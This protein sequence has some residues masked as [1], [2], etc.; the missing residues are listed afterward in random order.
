MIR[1]DVLGVGVDALTRQNALKSALEM[2]SEHRGAYMVTPNPEIVMAAW[3]DPKVCEA[4]SSAD[5]VIAD[6]VGVLMA[7]KILGRPLPER[8]TG[9][10]IAADIMRELS[11]TGGSVFL[12]GAKAGVAE[13]AARNIEKLFPGLK[14]AGVND[15]YAL[16]DELLDR[17]NALKPDFLLVCLGAGR[18]ELWMAKNAEKLDVGLMAGLGGTLDVLSGDTKRA[19]ESWQRLNLEWLYRCFEDPKRFKKI[20]K[21]PGF[22]MKAYRERARE[23]K[24]G[25]R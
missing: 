5:I 3:D 1:T 21:F 18:Q 16:D 14:V 12:L 23:K 2:I 24:N 8:V 10:D 22:L 4:L 25:K 19:P 15:G 20:L 7:A 13:K 17:I 9:I 6:G 11:L